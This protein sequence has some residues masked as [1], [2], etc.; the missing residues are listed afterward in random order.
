MIRNQ[1]NG[2]YNFELSLPGAMCVVGI[3][4]A[5]VDSIMKYN[6]TSSLKVSKI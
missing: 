2:K 1:Q 6:I 5:V 3:V 4:E